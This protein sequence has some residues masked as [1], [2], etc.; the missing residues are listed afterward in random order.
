[1]GL[2]VLTITILGCLLFSI[3]VNYGKNIGYILLLAIIY[4]LFQLQVTTL[5]LG[6]ISLLKPFYL[7]G[8]N[9][10]ISF[11]MTFFSI[12]KIEIRKLMSECG[13]VK[14]GSLI[15][16][17]GIPA[18]FFLI[19]FI[20]NS[21]T[22]AYRIHVFPDF[23]WDVN[24]YHLIA[25]ITWYQTQRIPFEIESTV[26]RINYN[27]SGTK[28]Y[29]YWSILLD[30]SLMYVELVQ[31]MFALILF[32]VIYLIMRSFK[33]V[34][35]DAFIF[36]ILA[37]S[38][39]TILIQMRT[40]HDH[41]SVLTMTF[42]LLFLILDNI[43]NRKVITLSDFLHFIITCSILVCLKVNGIINLIVLLGVFLLV[44]SK[45][46]NRL[47]VNMPRVRF[48]LLN[49]ILLIT[50]FSSSIFISFYWPLS[51]ILTGY[52]P[53][54]SHY[55]TI[56]KTEDSFLNRNSVISLVGKFY[57]NMKELPRRVIDISSHYSPDSTDIS[58]YGI[59]FLSVGLVS[60][61]L[62]AAL[63][64][65]GYKFGGQV[66]IRKAIALLFLYGVLSQIFYY[67]LYFTKHNYRLFT[68]FPIIAIIF[69]SY[70]WSQVKTSQMQRI[71]VYTL[72]FFLI[73]YNYLIIPTSENINPFMIKSALKKNS[74]PHGSDLTTYL[75]DEWKFINML[76]LEKKVVYF[77]HADGFLLPYYD[78]HLNTTIISLSSYTYSINNGDLIISEESIL[79]MK[80][81]GV[82]Y[83]HINNQYHNTLDD[84][85]FSAITGVNGNAFSNIYGG[86]YELNYD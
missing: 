71:A 3:R 72:F 6:T 51:N 19:L 15:S 4:L 46:F 16:S 52:H 80:Q 17:L 76:P 14:M 73:L 84:K 20:I 55:E 57:S 9:I 86:L 21:A 69:A 8:F 45:S 2:A 10:L 41:M 59:Q 30:D 66:R 22:I 23:V 75:N 43:L 61:L 65:S 7:Y 12:R 47:F 40:T 58:G 36:S 62:V 74:Q 54:S 37:I 39:P 38:F 26:D 5:A 28:I 77:T 32:Y 53:L 70:L 79:K 11:I 63:L 82:D 64:L 78:N 49:V 25:P 83:L 67:F 31:Y 34:R 50:I 56:T 48:S 60:Y 68:V 35:G 27:Y 18:I 33:I 1:M 44:I 29:N 13:R 81:Q 85:K 24:T 42:V